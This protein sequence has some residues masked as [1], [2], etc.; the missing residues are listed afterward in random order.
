[1]KLTKQTAIFKAL[2]SE[3][4][5]RLFLMI[6]ENCC[7]KVDGYEKAFTDAC[8]CLPIG[9][10]TVSHHL[11][12]LQKAGLITCERE[13]QSMRCRVNKRALELIRKVLA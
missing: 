4:R 7:G 11:K 1:M 3:Q 8:E 6:M 9:R 5:L 10:S 13:G 2:A 12:E